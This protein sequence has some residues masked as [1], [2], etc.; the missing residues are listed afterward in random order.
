[1]GGRGDKIC[2]Y[3]KNGGIS[4]GINSIVILWSESSSG[5]R[6]VC[7]ESERPN[8]QFSIPQFQIHPYWV[9]DNEGRIFKHFYFVLWNDVNPV[10]WRVLNT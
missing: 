6:R 7:M 1:M 10:Q 2:S 8:Q 4:L 9:C 5:D 3:E